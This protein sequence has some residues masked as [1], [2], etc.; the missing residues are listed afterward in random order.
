MFA[1]RRSGPGTPPHHQLLDLGDGLGR[2]E[3]LQA[4]VGVVHDGVAAEEGACLAMSHMRTTG[5]R[6]AFVR[7]ADS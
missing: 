4:G 3:A 2:V 5:G 6:L 1:A 7:R